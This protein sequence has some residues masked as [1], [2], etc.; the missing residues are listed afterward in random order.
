MV[1][2]RA[3]VAAVMFT[4]VGVVTALVATVNVPVVA[5]AATETEAGTVAAALL[6]VSDTV[7]P[8]E[9]A[10]EASVTVPV[11]E[12]VP[13]TAFGDT[14]TADTAGVAAVVCGV[15]VLLLPPPQLTSTMSA[16]MAKQP[17]KR[18]NQVLRLRSNPAAAPP[19][20]TTALIAV[21]ASDHGAC[22]G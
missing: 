4:A 17:H 9:G 22:N 5:P 3:L 2:D 19:Q 8:P 20:N 21:H 11:T 14:E 16:A 10:A 18:A 1:C 12:F 6:E 7:V 15:V 13:I